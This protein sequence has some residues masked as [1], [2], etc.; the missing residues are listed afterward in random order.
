MQKL[1]NLCPCCSGSSYTDCC[2]KF[3]EGKL[4][5]N[6]LL[7][8]R[9]RYSA[10]ALNLADYIIETTHPKNPHYLTDTS[11]WKRN[12]SKFFQQTYFH[13]LE[14]HEFQENNTSAIVIFTAE[15]SQ[16]LDDATFSEKSEFEKIKG[17]WLYRDGKITTGRTYLL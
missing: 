13:K 5:Q 9:S 1:P 8:M 2:K 15:I 14:I 4:P 17:R 6:A 7:L 10:Y 3:H 11:K 16:G 12:I